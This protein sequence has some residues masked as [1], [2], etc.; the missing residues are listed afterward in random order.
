MYVTLSPLFSKLN[1]SAEDCPLD[2]QGQCKV[3]AASD[4]R[5]SNDAPCPLS[6]HQVA[7]AAA[8]LSGEVDVIFNSA[9]TGDGKSLG[10]TLP[11]L[12]NPRFQMMGLYPT[13]ELVEDQARQQQEYHRLFRFEAQQI[14]RRIDRLYGEELN[15]R[16]S[17]DGSSKFVELG[18]ALENARVLLTNPDI[19]H[20][21]AHYRY[22]NPAY[23]N[24]ELPLSLA[25][26]PDLWIFDEFHIFGPHEETAAINAMTLIRSEQSRKKC[27]L[28]TSATPRTTFLQQLTDAGFTTCEIKG[29][30]A[31]GEAD[32]KQYRSIL[33]KI[34][35]GVANLKDR[36]AVTWLSEQA[37]P[38]RSHLLTDSGDRP[39]RG[40]VILNSIASVHRAVGLLRDRLAPEIEV[41][42]ISGRIDRRERETTRQ[43]LQSSPRPVLVIATSAVDVGVDFQIH[44]LVFEASNAATTIQ[45]LGRLGRHP[46]F[47]TYRAYLLIAGKVAYQYARL[48][49]ALQTEL[50][51]AQPEVPRDRLLQ[52][53]EQSFDLPKI[54]EEYRRRWGPLQSSGLLAQMQLGETKTASA[55]SQPVRDRVAASFRRLYGDRFERAR[56]QW[57]AMQHKAVDKEV[58]EELLRFRGGSALQVAVWDDTSGRDRFYTYDLLR[59]LPVAR[60][61]PL[62]RDAFIQKVRECNYPESGFPDR[63]LR[64]YW[65]V[66][67]WREQREEIQLEI[68]RGADELACCELTLIQGLQIVYYPEVSRALARKRLL[69]YLVPIP[70]RSSPWEIHRR[71]RLPATFGIYRLRD[72]DGNAYGCAFDRDALLLEALKHNLNDL[73]RSRPTAIVL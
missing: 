8:A 24:A 70:T 38:L 47:D 28:F 15:R 57:Y 31:H 18:A 71:L 43:T 50:A 27:F 21:I 22:R 20:L 66:R 34:E 45:R 35:L 64:G 67:Q 53:I 39:G 16:V 42:E 72:A 3:A 23:G 4:L 9:A 26:F 61:E 46:G 41:V 48:E 58:C 17:D 19:F 51:Q 73:C 33:Q 14:E 52:A 68:S 32:P 56:K 7:T 13:I 37:E 54:H 2:C 40:L 29:Q 69:V 5:A 44:L 10:A 30:Y 59:L 65:R 60:I 49:E 55:V 1:P 25:Q 11:A 62:D 12:L 36:D 6:S 63:Y